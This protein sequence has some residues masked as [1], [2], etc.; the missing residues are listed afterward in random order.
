VK[1]PTRQPGYSF[2]DVRLIRAQYELGVEGTSDAEGE[3]EWRYDDEVEVEGRTVRVRQEVRAR[4]VDASSE[5][6]VYLTASVVVEGRFESTPGANLEPRDF[7]ENHAPAILFAFTRECLHRLT[8]SAGGW[9]PILL[10]PVN[11]LELRRKKDA[12]A[13]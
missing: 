7:A 2:Q 4:V 8:S 9:P 3:L 12:V 1:D 5:D 13:K 11:V 10:P 6:L